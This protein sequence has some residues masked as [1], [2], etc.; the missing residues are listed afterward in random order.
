VEDHE[1]FIA[2]IEAQPNDRTTRL[3][4]ADFLDE[5]DNPAGEYLRAELR[6]ASLPKGSAD[7]PELRAKLR[8]LRPR[9]ESAWLA[10][11][12]QPRLMLANPTPFPSGWWAIGLPGVRDIRGTYQLLPFDTLPPLR[13]P[14]FTGTFDWL[15]KPTEETNLSPREANDEEQYEHHLKRLV[16]HLS[17]NKLVVPSD[18]LR[19]MADRSVQCI[20]SCTGCYP[21]RSWDAAPVAGSPG[22]RV[23][24]FYVDSQ[25]GV[26]WYLYLS[27]EGY[28]G[29]VAGGAR[30]CNRWH[31]I[32]RENP[33]APLDNN[34]P[35]E[36]D[37]FLAFV[38]PSVEAFF[39]RWWFEN[40]LW[41]KLVEPDLDFHDPTPVTP[42]ERAYIDFC[43]AHPLGGT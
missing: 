11:F 15:P 12:D 13:C 30:L 6:L 32:A 39:Y 29:V 28:S 26:I 33:S 18:F 38:A 27:P 7:A 35:T 43:R 22:S 21:R 31:R 8:T 40:T 10:R 16:R 3:V 4:Y 2:A 1:P 19:W 25:G 42:E 23:L 17:D 41:S 37:V 24:P 9:I 20:P 14:P 5:R 34:T 36:E